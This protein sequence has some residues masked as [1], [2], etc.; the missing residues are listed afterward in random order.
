MS[1]RNLQQTRVQYPIS[2]TQA[3]LA[4]EQA[5]SVR[6]QLTLGIQEVRETD[7]LDAL[8]ASREALSAVADARIG[9][10]VQRARF[11]L[12]LELMQLDTEDYWPS[13][14]DPLYQPVAN[15]F[16]P[17]SAGPTYG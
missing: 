6:L 14:N 1:L 10:L 16:Y 13:I 4:A 12:D 2:V 7:L 17:R 3:A 8:Q 15:S 5:I 9:Y 11:V